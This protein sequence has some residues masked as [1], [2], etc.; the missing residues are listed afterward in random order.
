MYVVKRAARLIETREYS[1]NEIFQKISFLKID[2]FT[3]KKKSDWFRRLLMMKNDF[4][5]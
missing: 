5:S 1:K 4:E 2:F 3:K